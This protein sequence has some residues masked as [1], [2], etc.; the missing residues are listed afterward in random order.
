M[1]KIFL[2]YSRKNKK[3]VGLLAAQLKA[4]GLRTW[5]DVSDLLLGKPTEQEIRQALAADCCAFLIYLTRQSL[6]S[7]YIM[8]V[9]LPAALRRQ[10][11]DPS[12]AII[13]V[14]H[15]V[16][17]SEA[18]DATMAATG[19]DM[20]VFHGVSIRGPKRITSEDAV[21]KLRSEFGKVARRA[22]HEYLGR[23]APTVSARR[24]GDLILDVHTKHYTAYPQ[25]ADLTLDWLSFFSDASLASPL[26]W[27][28]TLVPALRDVKE[29]AA[30]ECGTGCM[31]IRA[32]AHLSAG[33]ALGF[34]FRSPSG[35]TLD[36]TQG[37]DTWTTSCVPRDPAPLTVSVKGGS[38]GSRDLAA[39]LS[40]T[41]DVSEAVD[42]LVR[43]RG[44]D[45]RARVA[46][47]PPAGDARNAVAGPEEA[48]AM[49]V[50]VATDI[51][52]LREE[53][54][55]DVTHLFAAAPLALAVLLGH[56]LNACGPI[57]MY[58]YYN[59]DTKYVPSCLL[60]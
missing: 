25:A 26:V 45:F 22:L 52:R 51:R 14:F 44:R 18:G 3:H 31:H 4:R 5:Q 17:P 58:E 35:F 28:D 15:G 56:Q 46:F 27:S 42:K 41:G 30:Q 57:Q 23:R 54:G 1:D 19:R 60:A 9:E 39:E 48:L 6:Q 38:V 37:D 21:S 36:V 43:D 59:P 40:I 24:G 53:Y 2:S 11:Q 47:R 7:K 29:S 13:P 8:T 49:A 33:V 32:K 12:F 16:S 10:E 50:Q 20:A 55:A 34:A